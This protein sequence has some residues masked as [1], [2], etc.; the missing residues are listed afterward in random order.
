MV[1]QSNSGQT[2]R[3]NP[4]SVKPA[5]V[6]LLFSALAWAAP[7][8]TV[9]QQTVLVVPFENQ[10]RAPG[11][12]WIAEAFP[13]VLGERLQSGTLE[14][15]SREERVRAFD[16]FGLAANVLPSRATLFRIAEQMG[17]DYMVLGSYSYDGQSFR[18]SAQLLD[19]KR[20][21]L[22]PNVS[23]SDTLPRLL[24]VENALTWDLMQQLQPQAANSKANFLSS[25][26]PV[27]LDAF[28]N[29]IRGVIDT[30]PRD[31]VRHFREAVRLN[32]NYMQA[33]VAL[34]K[35]YYAMREY[36]PAEMWLSRVPRSDAQSSEA[37]FY[38]GLAAFYHGDF[39]RA[40]GAFR[41]L[42]SRV[43]LPEVYN[44]LGVVEARRGKKA[45]EYFQHAVQDDPGDADYHFNLAVA[46]YRTNDLAGTTKQLRETLSLRAGDTEAG[47]MLEELNQ[48]AA[49]P[50][51]SAAKIPLER[52]KTKYNESA[53]HQ[54]ERELQNAAEEKLASSDPHLHARFHVNRGKVLA[55][56]GF[57][58]DAE[59]EFRE[60]TTLEP[61]NSEAHLGL[62]ECLVNTNAAAARSEA[63]TTLRLQPSAGAFVV[64]ARLDLRDN[65]LQAAAQNVERALQVEPSNASAQELK[66][67]IAAKLA[68]NNR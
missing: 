26:A 52:I 25:S 56:Q 18:V 50:T 45:A 3:Y 46:L 66:R 41:F 22:L 43:P 44:D 29:Y 35:A 6:L 30:A 9:R 14:P 42:L 58:A 27:R 15:V 11:L 31:R 38:L 36:E 34:G 20:E 24:E 28:E 5:L 61:A 60:A 13:E 12:E 21:R 48:T 65:N 37:N 2:L 54:L 53:F 57:M 40:E 10:S 62:A 1:Q 51:H 63:E 7:V 68:E 4:R 32:P 16:H 47:A 39:E 19:I 64:L 49:E 67:T 8:P 33:I 23:E 17:V 55:G 59:R